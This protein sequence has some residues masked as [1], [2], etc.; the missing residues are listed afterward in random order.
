MQGYRGPRRDSVRIMI[1]FNPLEE[2]SKNKFS[3]WERF[4]KEKI[5]S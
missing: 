1:C 3:F 2:F 4:S 5:Q